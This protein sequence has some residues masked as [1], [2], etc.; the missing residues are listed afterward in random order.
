MTLTAPV[1]FSRIHREYC[2]KLRGKSSQ[3]AG[4]TRA[5]AARRF[6][7]NKKGAPCAPFADPGPVARD[8]S[9]PTS[10]LASALGELERP[11]RL[12]AAV[13]LALDHARIAGEEAA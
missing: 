4:K 5:N 2:A 8:A 3:N 13:F 10:A 12:A 9:A 6:T 1:F 11:A 7:P